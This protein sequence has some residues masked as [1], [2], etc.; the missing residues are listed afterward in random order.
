MWIFSQ[1]FCGLKTRKTTFIKGC[2]TTGL[3]QLNSNIR[4]PAEGS[5]RLAVLLLCI[6]CVRV[7]KGKTRNHEPHSEIESVE[8]IIFFF[9]REVLA[10]LADEF[11]EKSELFARK[12]KAQFVIN[13]RFAFINTLFLSIRNL[14]L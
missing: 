14:T 8:K 1:R 6:T 11:V 3:K 10:V 2:S 7:G 13:L 12:P 4:Q 9:Q 5:F